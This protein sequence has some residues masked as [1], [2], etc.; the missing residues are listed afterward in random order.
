MTTQSRTYTSL[1][2]SWMKKNDENLKG[3][4]G[5]RISNLYWVLNNLI[6]FILIEVYLICDIMLFS[7]I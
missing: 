2:P 3:D 6:L 4:P 1:Q 5:P 7:G